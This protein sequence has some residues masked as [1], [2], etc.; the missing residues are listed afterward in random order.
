M[1][2]QS[3]LQRIRIASGCLLGKN[4]QNDQ[5]EQIPRGRSPPKTPIERF[6]TTWTQSG[7]SCLPALSVADP[8]PLGLQRHPFRRAGDRQE[9][10]SY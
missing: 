3:R 1:D 9:P 2:A 7:R 4:A 5:A 10:G 6:Y 8:H